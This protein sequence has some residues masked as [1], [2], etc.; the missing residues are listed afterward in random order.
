MEAEAGVNMFLRSI[1]TRHLTFVGDGD[2]SCFS[3][4]CDACAARYGEVYHVI[5][6][7]C[8]GH[9]QKRMGGEGDTSSLMVKVLEVLVD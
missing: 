9:V 8:T 6:E 1:E 2:S 5:K 4:V 3:K 7:E